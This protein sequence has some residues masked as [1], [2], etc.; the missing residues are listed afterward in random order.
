MPFGCLTGMSWD[1]F[2]E[3]ILVLCVVSG[4]NLLFLLITLFVPRCARDED[5]A[6]SYRR[7]SV[8]I[9]IIFN[10]LCAPSVP[11]ARGDGVLWNS[12]VMASPRAGMRV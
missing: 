9:W 5:K 12:S 4:M 6:R 10:F 8:A 3:L 1:F 7:N 2:D 11:D